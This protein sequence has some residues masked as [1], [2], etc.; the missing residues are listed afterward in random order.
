MEKY[1]VL[2]K[3]GLIFKVDFEKAYEH[4][5]CQFLNL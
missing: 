5:D 4:V 3:E 2:N 1:R